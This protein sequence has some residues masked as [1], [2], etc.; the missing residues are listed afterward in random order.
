MESQENLTNT[1]TCKTNSNEY[2]VTVKGLKLKLKVTLGFW[3]HCGFTRENADVIEKDP[4]HY[5]NA[6]KLAVFYGNKDQYNWSSRED[7][8]KMLSDEDFEN[9][10]EDYSSDLS[11][12]TVWYLPKKIREITLRKIKEIEKQHQS[13]LESEIDKAMMVTIQPEE[14]TEDS[15]KK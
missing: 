8:S 5:L 6:L 15:K 2:I 4:T 7:M 11:M 1:E 13:M 3:R 9:C 12:A 14:N 10:E